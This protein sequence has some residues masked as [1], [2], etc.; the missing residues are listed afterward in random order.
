MS[1]V[2]IVVMMWLLKKRKNL[3]VVIIGFAHRLA[4]SETYYKGRVYI[5][6][7]FVFCV[8]ALYNWIYDSG[9]DLPK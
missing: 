8:T 1:I 6:P 4:S 3:L 7:D 2:M 5:T 9:T